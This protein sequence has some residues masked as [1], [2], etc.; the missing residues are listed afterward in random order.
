MLKKSAGASNDYLR[1]Y[2]SAHFNDPDEG[3]YLVRIS[4]GKLESIGKNT[5]LSYRHSLH[6][7]LCPSNG[8]RRKQYER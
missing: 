6:H 4:E 5:E 1:M 3:Q 2:D 7:L 8:P